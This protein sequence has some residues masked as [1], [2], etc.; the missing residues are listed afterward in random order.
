M[1]NRNGTEDFVIQ[2]IIDAVGP[3][4]ISKLRLN[5]IT[6]EY[7]NDVNPRCFSFNGYSL[8]A[9][10][11]P[12]YESF[13]KLYPQDYE[14]GIIVLPAISMVEHSTEIDLRRKI[15]I[16]A[17]NLFEEIIADIGQE[18]IP[19]QY[20]PI[21]KMVFAFA[22]GRFFHGS[23]YLHDRVQFDDDSICLEMPGFNE[24]LLIQMAK[25]ATL[26]MKL[27]IVLVKDYK[28]GKI[29]VVK[30]GCGTCRN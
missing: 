13:K 14:G 24:D 1:E 21:V 12:E 3:G 5:G 15:V 28:S 2:N 9:L 29:L 18:N 20:E 7:Y 30:C 25:L 17:H 4:W 23:V 10:P 19:V 22:V 6:V 26:Q 11:T 27:E 8:E 16:W